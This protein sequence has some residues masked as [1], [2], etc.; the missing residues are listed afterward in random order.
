MANLS[1][2]SFSTGNDNTF[3]NATI[4][5]ALPTGAV[6]DDLGVIFYVS[7]QG[8]SPPTHTTPSGWSARDTQTGLLLGGVYHYRVTIYDRILPSSPGATTL[9]SGGTCAHAYRYYAFDNPNTSGHFDTFTVRAVSASTNFD[10]TTLT[11]A[12]AN[13]MLLAIAFDASN[14]NA[15]FSSS[16]FT[17]HDDAA[18]L[19]AG[20]LIQASAG[21]SGS[22]AITASAARTGVVYMLAYKSEAPS[23]VSGSLNKTLGA[24]TGAGAGTVAVSG[25]L[26]KTLGAVTAAG[27]GGVAVSGTGAATLGA[28]TVDGEGTVTGGIEGTL[29][30]TL[31]SLAAAGTGTVDVSGSLSKTLDAATVIGTGTVDVA[32]AGAVTLGALVSAGAGAVAVDGAA[33]ITLG[34]LAL[35]GT[36]SVVSGIDGTL[37]K[38]LGEL[39]AA[40]TGAVTVEGALAVTLGE[41]A[42]SAAGESSIEG[43]L[44]KTLG[45]LV[46]AGVGDNGEVSAAADG[47]YL[48]AWRRWPRR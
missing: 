43:S 11:T 22:N 41:L 27:A 26:S 13:E 16:Q 12:E 25:S 38:T 3:G 35:A 4:S 9:T 5:A 47:G 39:A 30:Q 23:G 32:G 2:R 42:L 29:N 40:G 36:G 17:E 18:G 24:L 14:A 31:G 20:S 37:N 10:P 1:F 34:D 45:Q 48:L 33:S 8:S 15:A 19:Y 46:A 21:G 7:F 44:N 6:Q 28:L